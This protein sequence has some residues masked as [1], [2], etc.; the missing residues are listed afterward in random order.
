MGSRD[1]TAEL[2]D[3]IDV[4]SARGLELGPLTS[5][6][7][8]RDAGDVRYLDHVTTEELRAR[9]ATHEGFDVEAIV[10]ID[11]ASSGGS[12]RAAVGSDAP[13]DYVIASHVIEHV[14]D[15]IAWFHDLRGVLGDA[16]VVS[17]AVPDHRRCFDALRAPS[18]SAEV[19]AAHL[20]GASVPSP[21]Q[22]FDHV[23]SAV[24]WHG[25]IAWNEEPPFA[26]LRAVHAEHEALHG[27]TQV[28]TSGD[29]IDVH[30]WVFTPSSFTRLVST[31][32]RLGL[33]P[34]RLERCSDTIGGEFFARLR[35]AAPDDATHHEEGTAMSARG[36]EHAAVRA[37]LAAVRAERDAVR[38][39]L[40]RTVASRSWRLTRPVRA[41]NRRRP[42]RH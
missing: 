21:R 1:R 40:D 18:S 5:P 15:L 35:C 19:V 24:S 2:L 3:G 42:W 20:A 32:R 27:A 16:G 31:L 11:Y 14:P 10:P 12:M 17:L 38:A 8:R 37:E 7:V 28:S 26:E 34:F 29:Y 30:C 9:Y 22:V 25:V 6:V 23:A 4:A 41:L 13:F 39:E 33:L 36:S